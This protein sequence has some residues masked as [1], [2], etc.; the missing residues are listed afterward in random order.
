MLMDLLWLLLSCLGVAAAV[1]ICSFVHYADDIALTST[2]LKTCY[3][4]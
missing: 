2:R 3:F 4:N 1:D